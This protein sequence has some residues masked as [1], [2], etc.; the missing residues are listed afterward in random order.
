MYSRGNSIVIAGVVLAAVGAL[1]PGARSGAAEPVMGYRGDGSCVTEGA[2]PLRWSA[3]ENVLWRTPL[4]NWSY[5]HPVVAGGRVFLMTEPG[6]KHDFP[7]LNCLDADSG[8]VLWQ[9]EVNQLP[10]T[11]LPE[12]RQ[13]EVLA[14]YGEKLAKWRQSYRLFHKWHSSQDPNEKK[15]VLQRMAEMGME[16]DPARFQA[17]Y[18]VLRRAKFPWKEFCYRKA[19]F[20][21]E[22]WQHGCGYS[23]SCVGQAFP[24]PVTDGEH[25]YVATAFMGFACYDLDGNLRWLRFSPGSYGGKWGVDYCKFARSPLLHGNLLISDL[26]D[27]VRAFDKRTGELLWSHDKTGGKCTGMTLPAIITVGETDVLISK[28]HAYRLPDGKEL[29]VEGWKIQGIT[30]LVKHDEPDVLFAVGGGEHGNWE[31]K[32]RGETPSPVAVRFSLDGGTLQAKVLWSGSDTGIIRSHTGMVYH[33]GRLYLRGCIIDAET[34]EVL[35]GSTRRGRG[36]TPRTRHLLWVANG[37]LYGL[38]GQKARTGTCQV[39]TLDG[40][41]VA[42]NTLPAAEAVGEKKAQIIEQTGSATWSFS[43]GC[44]FTIAGDRI[45]IRSNDELWCIG[46]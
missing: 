14:E 15:R 30:R 38:S 39:Y 44:P 43:Y 28:S 22:T 8:E 29:A 23:L 10:V 17:S 2:P 26:A 41:K 25:V 19:G 31:A 7:V 9:R 36:A 18:G 24:T 4:A 21:S 11:G 37:H 33:D 34:G 42:E 35:A 45:Y 6:W 20:Q 46:K 1:W 13:E 5:S 12:A 32:G 16:F 40:K 27:V 3:E